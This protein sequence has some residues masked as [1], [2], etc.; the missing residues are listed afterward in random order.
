MPPEQIPE[1]IRPWGRYDILD[2]G[3]GYKVKRLTLNPDGIISYQR[4]ARRSEQWTITQGN[5]R[6]TLNDEIH[7]GNRGSYFSIPIGMKHRIQN[8]G[9]DPLL[10]IE[11]QQ[12]EYLE[13]DDIERLEDVYGRPKNYE[14][15]SSFMSSQP[16]SR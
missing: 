15:F 6:L 2:I 5:A 9:S 16:F 10:I 8:I 13:E 12:G 11:V 1:N 14:S 7:E 4:H 3:S